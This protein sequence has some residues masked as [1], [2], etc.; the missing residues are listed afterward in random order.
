MI[1]QSFRMA[2]KAIGGNKMRSF[3][4]ILGVVIGVV[5]IVVL[6]AIAQG[7]NAS[8]VSRIESMGTNMISVSIR[9]RWRNP[10]SLDDLQELSALEGIAYVAPVANVSGT[11]K[12]GVTTYD[13]A[14]IIGTTPDYDQ[15]RAYTVQMGRFLKNPDI[16]NRSFVA[17]IGTEAAMEMFGTVRVV[18]ET[19]TLNGYTFNVVGVLEE[20]GSS[21]SGSGDNMIPGSIPVMWGTALFFFT[22]YNCNRI[23][24]AHAGSRKRGWRYYTS[25]RDHPRACGE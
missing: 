24:P 12:A 17:V 7:A 13:D 4:T 25:A 11:V 16:D 6:V 18:G 14:S 3:L 10:I 2:L 9:A 22:L 5:A 23:T 15:I 8:V 20:M 19:F 21:I 1:Y